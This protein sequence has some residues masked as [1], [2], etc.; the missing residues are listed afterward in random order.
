MAIAQLAGGENADLKQLAQQIG[1]AQAKEIVIL[2]DWLDQAGEQ[3]TTME[4]KKM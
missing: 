3:L 1:T 4:M 2:L